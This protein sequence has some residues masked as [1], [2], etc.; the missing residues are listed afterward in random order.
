MHPLGLLHALNIIDSMTSPK[1]YSRKPGLVKT[2][3]L[4]VGITDASGNSPSPICSWDALTVNK[5][6][7]LYLTTTSL[8][9]RPLEKGFHHFQILLTLSTLSL[10]GPN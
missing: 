3:Q 8:V 1:V 5:D 4:P 2:T 10:C 6:S 9:E 7:F